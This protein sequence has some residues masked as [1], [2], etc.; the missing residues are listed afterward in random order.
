MTL[1]QFL[2]LLSAKIIIS[3][4]VVHYINML[5]SPVFHLFGVFI[6]SDACLIPEHSFTLIYKHQLSY[7]FLQVSLHRIICRPRRKYK[8][9]AEWK[10]N[11]IN[12]EY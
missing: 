2:T 9:I 1:S 7:P 8:I 5:I 4:I 11:P 6:S 10:R 3:S 12:F